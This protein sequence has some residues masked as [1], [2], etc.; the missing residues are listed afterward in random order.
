MPTNVF[1]NSNSNNSENRIDT[2]L[3]VQEPYLRTNYIEADIEED[4]NMKNQFKIKNLPCPQENSDGVCKFYVDNLFKD[5]SILK[6]TEHIDLNGRN[7]TNARFIQVNL[8]HQ[9]D[10]HLTAKLYVDYAIDE[11][12]LVRNN[13][14]NDFINNNLTNIGSITLNKQ[15]V[16][17]NEVITESYGD[18]F[19]NDNERTR[20]DSG[21]DFCDESSDLVKNNQDSDLNDSKLSNLD[22]IKVNRDPTSDNELANK[23]YVDDSIENR[24]L[25]YS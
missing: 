15:A 5:P 13:Q 2:S 12:S 18:L 3:F 21:L 9:F 20:R 1:G 4:I 14:D 24:R 22:S 17:D 16:N 19:H 23:K 25:Y 7:F 11:S 6:N 10:S 8:L